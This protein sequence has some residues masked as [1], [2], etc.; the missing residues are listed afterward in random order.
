MKV[1]CDRFSPAVITTINTILLQQLFISHR[2]RFSK[3]NASFLKLCLVYLSTQQQF[4]PWLYLL[5]Q[6]HWTKFVEFVQVAVVRPVWTE[7]QR[8]TVTVISECLIGVEKY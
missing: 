6:M 8:N 1:S 4:E 3:P 5:H 7:K 2:S